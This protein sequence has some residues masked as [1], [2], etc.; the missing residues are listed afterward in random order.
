MNR[1][2]YTAK[3]DP[4]NRAPSGLIGN[5]SLDEDGNP[6]HVELSNAELMQPDIE[7]IHMYRI[8]QARRSHDPRYAADRAS[9]GCSLESPS[10]KTVAHWHFPFFL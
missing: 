8:N 4:C 3:V 9:R 6:A 5:M 1:S 2:D 10:T 7:V